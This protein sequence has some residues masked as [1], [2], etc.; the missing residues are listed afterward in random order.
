MSEARGLIIGYGN[1]LRGDDGIGCHIADLL[2]RR[3]DFA[4][5]L[6]RPQLT[7]ELAD[8]IARAPWVVF[9]DASAEVAP[10]GVC[11]KE[12]IPDTA[13]PRMFSH[14]LTPTS[15][16]ACSQEF[17]GSA[18][19]SWLVAIGVTSIDATLSL[20]L[21]D[22]AVQTIANRIAHFAHEID[23]AELCSLS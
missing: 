20:T 1:T 16:L 12:V 22:T 17:F 11:T 2:A 6:S 13:L 9:V 10:G 7:V 5:V 18:P 8:D 21:D 4:R 19:P 14:H 15:L 23:T 3:T